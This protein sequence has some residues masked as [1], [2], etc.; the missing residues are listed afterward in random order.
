MFQMVWFCALLFFALSNLSYVKVP[1]PFKASALTDIFSLRAVIDLAGVLLSEMIFILK[2]ENDRK[3]E[4]DAIRSVLNTQYQQYRNSQEN[5]DLVNRK[6]HD[7]KNLLVALR[8]QESSD[9]RLAY[10][11]EAEEGLRLYEAENKTGNSVLDTILT[12]KSY[13][14]LKHDIQLHVVADGAL[15][16]SMHVTDVATIFGNALDNAIEHEIQIPEKEKRLIRVSLS[17]RSQMAI[18]LIE[19]YF[20]GELKE[21]PTGLLTIKGDTQYHG[22]GIKSIRFAV[23]KYHG[24][25]T[26]GVEDG[27]FQLKILLPLS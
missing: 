25:M 16:G 26:T 3:T 11:D 1:N 21:G 2:S 12:S 24:V 7:M 13:R 22:Y 20:Q 9:K 15:L 6:Y 14:C 8:A 17:R 5:I 19:N 23:Q 27:W 4:L 10:L 18:I